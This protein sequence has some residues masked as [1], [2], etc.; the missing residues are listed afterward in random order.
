MDLKWWEILLIALGGVIFL[1]I[2]IYIFIRRRRRRG[3]ASTAR[4]GV[5]RA[6]IEGE[7]FFNLGKSQ[8][9][10]TKEQIKRMSKS[11]LL[12]YQYQAGLQGKEVFKERVKEYSE[13]RTPPFF[14]FSSLKEEA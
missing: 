1:G 5:S 6:Y 11:A 14:D 10:P 2:I 4:N 12:A 8:E 9:P 13:L 7:I 3:A